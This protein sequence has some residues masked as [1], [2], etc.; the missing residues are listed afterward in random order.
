MATSPLNVL[1]NEGAGI[2]EQGDEEFPSGTRVVFGGPFGVLEAGTYSEFVAVP[3][4]MLYRV[5]PNV[6]LIEAAGLPVAYIS[7]YIAL[8]MA[9]FAAGK[10]VYASGVFGGIGN[11]TL[12]LARARPPETGR[13]LPR[14]RATARRPTRAGAP[15]R[16]ILGALYLTTDG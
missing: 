15:E 7:A 3:K 9:G 11:A 8:D 1:G 6:D 2:F 14:H 10:V 12:Q 13:C 16:S 4:P 5:P